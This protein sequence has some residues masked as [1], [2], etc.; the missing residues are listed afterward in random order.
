MV[1][2]AGAWSDRIVLAKSPAVQA[3]VRLGLPAT[4]LYA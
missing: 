4:Y 2:L 3:C 1:K